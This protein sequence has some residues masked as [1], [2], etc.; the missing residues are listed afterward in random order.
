MTFQENFQGVWIAEIMPS[1]VLMGC[2]GRAI[3]LASDEP[4]MKRGKRNHYG[5]KGPKPTDMQQRPTQRMEP[6]A[7][8]AQRLRSWS[9]V[10]QLDL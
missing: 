4:A 3:E 5:R 8:V 10:A 9:S 7:R 2:K 1:K 6:R